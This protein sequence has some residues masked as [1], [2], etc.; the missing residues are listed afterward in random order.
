MAV[1]KEVLLTILQAALD[2]PIGLILQTSDTARARAAFYKAR[3]D[4][5]DPALAAL[6]IRISPFPDGDLV[7][8]HPA[9]TAKRPPSPELGDLFE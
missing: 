3:A 4:S 1:G 7:I 5:G 2:E 8:C 9:P 6:Q